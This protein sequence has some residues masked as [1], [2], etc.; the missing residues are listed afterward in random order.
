MNT[1][2]TSEYH[3]LETLTSFMHHMKMCR[4]C[5]VAHYYGG[6]PAK[7]C[8]LGKELFSAWRMEVNRFHAKRDADNGE[9]KHE[10]TD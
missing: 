8:V 1:K 10:T 4:L 9:N 7:E 2:H 5:E 3:A 6:M